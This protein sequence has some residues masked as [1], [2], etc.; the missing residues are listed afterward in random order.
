M[1]IWLH[2]YKVEVALI[3]SILPDAWGAIE[4]SGKD[5]TPKD[6]AALNVSVLGIW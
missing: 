5:E 6:G 4:G 3:I 2:T 1:V